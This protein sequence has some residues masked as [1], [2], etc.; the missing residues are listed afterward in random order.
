MSD[1]IKDITEVS[2]NLVRA[3]MQAEQ[4]RLRPALRLLERTY[5]EAL[6]RQNI[7][8]PTTVHLAIEN[9]LRLWKEGERNEYANARVKLDQLAR[10]EG[11]HDHDCDVA[12]RSLRAGM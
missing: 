2:G 11:R 1:F 6:D 3:G 12:G 10:Y 8:A 9:L 5:R 4:D 7:E